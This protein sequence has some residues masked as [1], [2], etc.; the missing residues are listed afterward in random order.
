MAVSA[1][2]KIGKEICD[3]LGLKH[4]CEMDIHIAKDEIITIMAKIY[5]DRDGVKQLPLMFQ[6]FELVAKGEP[7][8]CPTMVDTTCIGDEYA[9]GVF[10]VVK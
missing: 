3:V 1:A 7:K 5:P 6:G 10:K 4:C 8:E 9:D 2:D